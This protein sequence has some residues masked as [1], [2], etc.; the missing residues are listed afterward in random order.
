MALIA[1]YKPHK[2][3][4]IGGYAICAW[5][6]SPYSH[7]EVVID[8][9]CYT[10]SLMDG[11]V[12]VKKIDL[13]GAHWDLLDASWINT[14]RVIEFYE[15]TKGEPYGYLDLISQH[16]LRLPWHQSKGWLCSEWI[17]A[18][19]NLPNSRTWTPGMVMDYA[20]GRL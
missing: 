5:T 4:D 14:D 12:R 1:G 18:A 2:L 15:R 11:G 9:L 16:V 7:V 10:S 6:R 3:T 13:S 19:A 8:G 20:R 17:A